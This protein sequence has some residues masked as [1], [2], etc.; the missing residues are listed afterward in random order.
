[1]PDTLLPA[2]PLSAFLARARELYTLPAAALK[3]LELTASPQVDVRA[4]K[5]CIE[6]DP[7]LTAKLL[8]VVNS[9]L[10]GLSRQV[11]DLN[12]ALALLGVKP[13][14]L[15]VLG[16]SLPKA[17]F[18]GL[19]T[20][21]LA[22]YWRR[23]LTKAA[24][25]REMSEAAFGA[26]SDEAFIAGLLQDLGQL[27]LVQDLGNAYLAFLDCVKREKE[28]LAARELA[29]LGFD[30]AMYSA[31]LLD[32]W[33]LPK[34]LVAA[35]AER[36]DIEHLATLSE[37][38]RRLPQALHLA[39]LAAQVLADGRAEALDELQAAA[40]QYAALSAEDVETVL[41]HLQEKVALLA[42][43]LDLELSEPVDCQ[44][45]LAEAKARRCVIA[46]S[47]AKD[48]AHAAHE[49]QL[50]QQVEALRVATAEFLS[51][52]SREDSLR[53]RDTGDARAASP[54]ASHRDYNPAL[55]GRIEMALNRCRQHRTAVSVLVVAIDQEEQVAFTAGADGLQRAMK[56]VTAIASALCEAETASLEASESSVAIVLEGGDRPQ[57]VAF[58]RRLVEM[59]AQCAGAKREW[60]GRALT[61]SVGA[62]TLPLPPRNFPPRELIEAARRCLSAA[63]SAGGNVVKSIDIC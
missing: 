59:V 55:G 28:E 61:V 50:W 33:G 48:L 43:A 6:I 20:E 19:E 9:S 37:E 15:L 25:A 18:D 47:A 58:G 2:A 52:P 7:A 57:A 39:E 31:R 45:M 17:L 60:F 53:K 38:N 34:P 63:R 8:R 36:Q 44:R 3:V 13:L 30:H 24:A 12:Q 16:F 27:A 51:Q 21:M 41:R 32:Q 42:E 23:T 14:K 35:I 1:M 26:S 4:L 40:A 49:S 29:T 22:A 54:P 56:L 46:A 10:F 5:N 11:S 62:A